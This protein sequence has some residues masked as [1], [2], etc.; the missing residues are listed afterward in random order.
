M[1]QKAHKCCD[2][3]HTYYAPDTVLLLVHISFIPHNNSTTA[4]CN[5]VCSYH[6]IAK[7]TSTLLDLCPLALA[8]PIHVRSGVAETGTEA[9]WPR[10]LQLHTNC[11]VPT[12]DEPGGWHLNCLPGHSKSRD[13]RLWLLKKYLLFFTSRSSHRT[14]D[15]QWF[16]QP[17][18]S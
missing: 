7:K 8:K 4:S 10:I 3:L 6:F 9:V 17:S 12:Q 2:W 11:I 18:D 15:G 1:E 5:R 14:L 13:N 16:S